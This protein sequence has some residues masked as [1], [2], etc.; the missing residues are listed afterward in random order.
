MRKLIC[1]VTGILML[2]VFASCTTPEEKSL[3]SLQELYQDLE[4]NHENYTLEDWDKAQ[5]EYELLS[6][7]IKGYQYTDE[8]LVEIGRLQGKC[9]AYLTKG[10]FKRLERGI[11]QA[12]GAIKGYMEGMEQMTPDSSSIQE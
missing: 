3:R 7:Q 1:I 4:Q 8:Q 11:I 2:L 6:T 10:Y 12:T 5:A 9:A